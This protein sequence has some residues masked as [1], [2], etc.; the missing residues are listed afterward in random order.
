MLFDVLTL[1]DDLERKD[2]IPSSCF[3]ETIPMVIV[4]H[5]INP[6]P[7]KILL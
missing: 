2:D 7:K 6:T 5:A 4:D 3:D 1:Y